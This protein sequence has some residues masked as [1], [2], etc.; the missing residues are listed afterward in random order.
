[1]S[2]TSLLV[3]IFRWSLFGAFLAGLFWAIWALSGT[4]IPVARPLRFPEFAELAPIG[5]SSIASRAWDPLGLA[6]VVAL[7]ILALE[8]HSRFDD[9]HDDY[10]AYAIGALGIGA[11][12]GGGG[13]CVWLRLTPEGPWMPVVLAC[14]ATGVG[15][16]AGIIGV[17]TGKARRALAVAVAG[18]LLFCVAANAVGGF[19]NGFLFTVVATTGLGLVGAALSASLCLVT[20]AI[21]QTGFWSWTGRLRRPKFASFARLVKREP[22][23]QNLV[24]RSERLKTEIAERAAELETLQRHP[25]YPRL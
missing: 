4:S 2:N 5:L 21:L 9:W 24:A 25:D 11:L 8:V 17:A 1:M 6:L 19:V 18:P 15:L 3:R 20:L 7:L 22:E 16:V 10:G 12:A 14:I 13:F 23:P